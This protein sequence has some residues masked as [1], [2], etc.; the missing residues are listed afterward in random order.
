MGWMQG[1]AQAAGVVNRL[2]L[3]GCSPAVLPLLTASSDPVLP[4]AFLL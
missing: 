2:I 1:S 3:G 4:R